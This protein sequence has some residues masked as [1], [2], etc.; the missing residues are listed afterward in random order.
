MWSWQLALGDTSVRPRLRRL[1][2][3]RTGKQC[4]VLTT[5][6]FS[7]KQRSAK[8]ATAASSRSEVV[9]AQ[10]CT[11][12]NPQHDVVGS[13][14]KSQTQRLTTIMSLCGLGETAQSHV[15]NRHYRITARQ[16]YQA[17]QKRILPLHGTREPSA[18]ILTLMCS[19]GV[20]KIMPQSCLPVSASARSF[21][22]ESQGRSLGC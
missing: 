2:V 5:Q 17:A 12:A 15:D 1:T 20:P 18:R 19:L 14:T 4:R 7:K 6:Q 21:Y 16:P 13:P 9:G 10:R 3:A 8:R 22:C 11:G